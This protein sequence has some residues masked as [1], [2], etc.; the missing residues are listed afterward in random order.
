MADLQ[1]GHLNIDYTLPATLVEIHRDRTPGANGNRGRVY[2]PHPGWKSLT[3]APRLNVN[4][5]NVAGNCHRL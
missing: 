5:I 3:A 2:Y 4:T 1:V